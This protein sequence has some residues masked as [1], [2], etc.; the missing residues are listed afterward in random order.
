MQPPCAIIPQELL[1]QQ[2]IAEPTIGQNVELVQVAAV[3]FF[4]DGLSEPQP[5]KASK[6][7]RATKTSAKLRM[8]AHCR[9]DRAEGLD[10][11]VDTDA[12]SIQ[13]KCRETRSVA[14]RS[15]TGFNRERQS[16]RRLILFAREHERR[17]SRSVQMIPAE[18]TSVRS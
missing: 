14:Q 7:A 5:S 10:L 2:P 15:Y 17:R 13:P 8:V 12:I 18:L 6:P 1:I 11:P 3:G 9:T 4:E 16:W